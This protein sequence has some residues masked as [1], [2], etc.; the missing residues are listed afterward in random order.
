MAAPP[1]SKLAREKRQTL[2]DDLNYLN[3]SEI[4]TFCKQ[5]RI[6]FTIMVEMPDGRRK[7]T[8]DDD[9]KGVILGRIRH[10]LETGTILEA[11][12]FPAAVV[13]CG[14]PAAHLTPD[15]RLYYG[16]YDKS[17]RAMVALLKEL[18]DG[19]FQNG[20]VA[21][22]LAREFW[23]NG[24]APTFRHFAAAWLRER[25]AHTA[26][27]AEWA[28]LSDRAKGEASPDW[29]KLRAKRA[30]AVIELLKTLTAT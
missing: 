17:N 10:F 20:A 15:D 16:Q 12:C 14:P 24:E 13:R 3:T 11:T 1:I 9:R 18:T 22:I 2:L 28:F 25:A 19:H 30:A 8:A 6:P 29:K 27:N 5:H 23:T 21:R 7:K 26:P 4:K